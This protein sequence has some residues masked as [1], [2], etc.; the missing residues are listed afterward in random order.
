MERGGRV[1]D[2]LD[3]LVEAGLASADEGANPA[4]G[5]AARRRLVPAILGPMR[6][7]DASTKRPYL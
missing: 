3:Q 7:W 1:S 5:K 2:A 4:T 6:G